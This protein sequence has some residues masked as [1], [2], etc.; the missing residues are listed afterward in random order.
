VDLILNPNVW[1]MFPHT[2]M[3]GF[4]TGA[5]FV[6]GVS[7]YHLLRKN[8]VD[9]FR[10][11]F[12]L[13]AVFGVIATILVAI[14][15]HSQAQHMVEAQPMKMAAAEAL[16]RTETP[17]SF[18][19]LTIGDLTQ[20]EEVFSIRLP[21]LLCLLAYDNLNCTIEGIRDLQA[22]YEQQY[23]PGDYIP[24]VAVIYWTFRIMVGIGFLLILLAIW[25]L[26]LAMGEILEK[27]PQALRIFQWALFLPYL[28]NTAGWMLTE[29]GRVPWLVYGL[30]R[31]EDGV[32][33]VVPAGSVLVSLIVYTLVY[34]ALMVAMVYLML[35]YARA[36]VEGPAEPLE[37]PQGLPSLVGAQD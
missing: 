8:Q 35:K 4:A 3:S 5:F 18:S 17:A 36:G 26:F 34:A 9:I 28:A 7:A 29:F 20:R 13:A 25:G 31:L 16:W 23:G 37:A 33:T 19:L 32:S 22:K 21:R 10:R 11:S 24:P 2:L 15:G 27:R 14:N 6:M 30:M 1:V 12:Q